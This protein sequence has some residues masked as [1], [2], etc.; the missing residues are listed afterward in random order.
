VGL[1]RDLRLVNRCIVSAGLRRQFNEFY[2]KA[3]QEKVSPSA[4]RGEDFCLEIQPTA[5]AC[6]PSIH[7]RQFVGA[8]L[9]FPWFSSSGGDHAN[10][11][12][13]LGKRTW[14]L[15]V[16]HGSIRG[17]LPIVAWWTSMPIYFSWLITALLSVGGDT[18]NLNRQQS[19]SLLYCVIS[20][21][22][23]N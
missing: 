6:A 20:P 16:N 3:C 1:L 22:R 12:L 18:N 2:K 11:V 10:R 23:N 8:C 5:C 19:G 4:G 17:S 21:V 15:D 9:P 13:D 14:C 7:S